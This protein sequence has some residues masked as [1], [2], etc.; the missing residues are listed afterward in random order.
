VPIIACLLQARE[1]LLFHRSQVLELAE[2]S[3]SKV[4][5]QAYRSARKKLNRSFCDQ[6]ERQ[7]ICWSQ[8][9]PHSFKDSTNISALSSNQ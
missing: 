5:T 7:T 3:E 2:D 6:K 9:N 1:T 4:L 8:R